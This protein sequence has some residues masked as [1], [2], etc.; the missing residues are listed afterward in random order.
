VVALVLGAD[1]MPVDAVESAALT[2]G[3]TSPEDDALSPQPNRKSAHAVS[4]PERRSERTTEG[5][6]KPSECMVLR[7]RWLRERILALA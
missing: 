6:A 2:P 1:V 3:A 5:R 7:L 4:T